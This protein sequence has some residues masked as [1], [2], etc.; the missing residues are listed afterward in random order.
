MPLK[1]WRKGADCRIKTVLHWKKVFAIPYLHN[2]KVFLIHLYF[3]DA[4]Q[5]RLNCTRVLN[6]VIRLNSTVSFSSWPVDSINHG[7][8]NI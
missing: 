7:L 1:T 8:I 3:M 4:I 6:A 2:C 5:R